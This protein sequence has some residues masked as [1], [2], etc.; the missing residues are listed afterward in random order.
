ME[1]PG[2]RGA[3]SQSVYPRLAA[4]PLPRKPFLRW[5]EGR[6]VRR[7]RTGVLLPTTGPALRHLSPSSASVS[8]VPSASD[9]TEWIRPRAS[10]WTSEPRTGQAAVPA[11]MRA[12]TAPQPE[13]NSHRGQGT[14]SISCP[15]TTTPDPGGPVIL[16]AA[17]QL[18][19]EVPASMTG[20]A[21]L[22]GWAQNIASGF[23]IQLNSTQHGPVV[24][25][26]V[27]A[28]LSRRRSRVRIPSGPRSHHSVMLLSSTGV[29]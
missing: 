28:A 18:L 8:V 22:G 29:I 1:P 20:G 23:V 16:Y 15:P 26:G 27:H 7:V 12:P 25:P 4:T 24:K 17:V 21:S 14:E 3:T 2:C 10:R 13:Q 9:V 11:V 5:R 19:S 6:S